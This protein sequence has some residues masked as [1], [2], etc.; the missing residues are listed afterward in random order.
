MKKKLEIIFF[1]FFSRRV[2]K[3]TNKKILALVSP[4]IVWEGLLY[5]FP[6]MLPRMPRARMFLLV[7][8]RTLLL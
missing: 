1:F 7:D 2:C 6:P 8:L 5:P 4:E 3:S